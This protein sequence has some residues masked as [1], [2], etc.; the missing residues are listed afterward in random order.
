MFDKRGTG[1]SDPVPTA[2]M[3]ILE[4]WMDDA[5]AVL[6]AVG[7]EKAAVIANLGG[8]YIAM[9]LAAAHPE[10]VSHLVLWTAQ[11]VRPRHRI[12]LLATQKSSWSATW[13]INRGLVRV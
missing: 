3:P 13:P 5:L 9:T 6:D 11:H 7:S 1:L 8:G 4:S 2:E 10:R 12:S